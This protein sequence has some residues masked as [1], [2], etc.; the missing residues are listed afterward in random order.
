MTRLISVVLLSCWFTLVHAAELA[1]ANP[2]LADSSYPF[3]HG[4][5]AQQD[6]VAAAGPLGRTRNLRPAEIDYV[7]LGPGAFGAY[8]SGPYPDGKRVLW[9][10]TLDRIVKLDYDTHE[11]LAT[12]FT[13]GAPV[14]G[15]TQAWDAIDYFDANN[16][17]FFAIVR[18]FREAQKL[19][20]LAAVY[21]LVDRN[22]EYFVANKAGYLEAYG[23]LQEGVRESAVVLRRRFDFPAPLAGQDAIGLNMT[24]DGW[25]VTVT[26]VGKLL[27]VKRDFSEFRVGDLQHNSGAEAKATRPT[28][29]GWVRNAAALDDSGGIYVVSQEYMHKVIWT[30]DGF[31]VDAAD[32]AWAVPYDNSWG[33]GSGST[34]SLMGFGDEEDKLVVITD[35]NPG[36]HVNAFW[37]EAIP[38]DW[39]G[40][41]GQ[42]RRLAGAIKVRMGEQNLQT[43]QSEQSVAVYGYGALV[44]NNGPRNVP[45]YL[46]EQAQT[47]LISFLG[48]SPQYQP[49]GVEKF[50]WNPVANRFER[51]WTN[52][53]ISSP[54]CMP[55]LSKGSDT[56]Y[57]IGARDNQ[58]TLE[59][60]DWATGESRFHYVI[61]G[62][63]YNPLF[64]GTLLDSAGRIHYGTPWGR[65]RLNPRQ[66]R[67]AGR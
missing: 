17:G 14:W 64:S 27:A 50:E 16:E 1:P 4:D 67:T 18:A 43:I 52:N 23:D 59:A 22:N 62:Q 11:M 7:H 39:A 15:E 31:S 2:Y 51:A 53:T 19:R 12:W 29:Y 13:Q 65:V 55:I 32:G 6:V 21:T 33:H 63:R 60:I 61:G 3:P 57:L 5:T 35:G 38:E 49:F 41:P 30:G 10:N 54:N 47:L 36:M 44:V 45:W 8:T 66:A 40:L 56:A 42:P 48:S 20:S 9:T 26:D 46:P 58:W 25:I 37:R 24:P 34:P 28:G